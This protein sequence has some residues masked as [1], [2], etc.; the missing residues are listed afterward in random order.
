VMPIHFQAAFTS[1]FF[2][3]FCDSAFLGRITVSTP[4]LKVASILSASTVRGMLKSMT[5]P[6]LVSH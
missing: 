5:V 2:A 3:G 1:T 6:V 4:F